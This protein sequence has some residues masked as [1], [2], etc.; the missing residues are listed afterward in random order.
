MTS[1]QFSSHHSPPVGRR[2]GSSHHS[3]PVGRRQGREGGGGGVT[4]CFLQPTVT[5][6]RITCKKKTPMPFSVVPSHRKTCVFL[7]GIQGVTV[8]SPFLIFIA[9]TVAFPAV[10][11]FT[12]LALFFLHPTFLLSK[13][14][15]PTP[16]GTWI[17][18]ILRGKNRLGKC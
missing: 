2:Q 16:L 9:H 10:P 6:C 14:N 3:P 4:L 8:T 15:P 5:T 17:M 13:P 12:C 18:V 11:S 7:I 1:G